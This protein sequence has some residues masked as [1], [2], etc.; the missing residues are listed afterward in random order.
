MIVLDTNVISEL[1]RHR[2]DPGVL[3]W[4]DARSVADLYVTS[5]TV[6]E[7]LYGVERLPPGRRR[8]GLGAAVGD[9]ITVDFAGRVLPFD[10]AAAVTYAQ[11]VAERERAG[12]PI[13]MAD[14]MIAAVALEVG[15][16]LVTRNVKDFAGVGLDLVDPWDSGTR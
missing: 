11:V 6:A 8:A 12:H 16:V 4:V 3:A 13:G 5:V 2:P 15:A 1:V 10:A 9:L 14:A 7:L